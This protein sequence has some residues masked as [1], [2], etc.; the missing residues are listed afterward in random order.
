MRY[1]T[2]ETESGEWR[3][4]ALAEPAVGLTEEV[5]PADGAPATDTPPA[6]AAIDPV[7]QVDGVTT[8]P[9]PEAESEGN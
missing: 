6:E 2:G 3:D 1:A 8:D 5:A 9:A 7:P 4:G